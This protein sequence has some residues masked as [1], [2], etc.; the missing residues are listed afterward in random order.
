MALAYKPHSLRYYPPSKHQTDLGVQ[1][2]PSWDGQSFEFRGQV[3]PGAYSLVVERF[4]IELEKP[5]LLLCDLEDGD[6][7]RVG[8]VVVHADRRYGVKAPPKRWQ[9]IA[10]TYAEVVLEELDHEADDE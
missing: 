10:P 2:V 3:T 8:G 5:M 4:G 1:R 6:L 7:M 9:A